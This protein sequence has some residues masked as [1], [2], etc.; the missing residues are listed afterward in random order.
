M[1]GVN[2]GP[3]K[4][5]NPHGRGRTRPPRHDTHN[6][7]HL[8][9]RATST[10]T[11]ASGGE[12]MDLNPWLDT[13]LAG[14]DLCAAWVCVGAFALVYLGV[15]AALRARRRAHVLELAAAVRSGGDPQTI[16]WQ[17]AFVEVNG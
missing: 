8:H 17:L 2:K 4:G 11:R 5:A 9:S 1:C 15:V 7:G 6:L 10:Q 14:G 13:S 12:N 3:R 16:A